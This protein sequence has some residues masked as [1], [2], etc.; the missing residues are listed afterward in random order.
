M[1]GTAR[2][3]LEECFHVS[4]SVGCRETCTWRRMQLTVMVQCVQVN[5]N[6]RANCRSADGLFHVG[7]RETCT[8]RRMQLTV[9]VPC[10][11]VNANTCANCWSADGPFHVSRRETCTWRKMQLT[12]TIPCAQVIVNTR[13]N[14]RS[15]DGPF[16]VGLFTYSV[17]GTLI[18]FKNMLQTNVVCFKV[19]CNV[20]WA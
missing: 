3:S 1:R 9:A 11:Q 16:P 13:A 14:C 8:C 12:V 10:A 17:T 18:F 20:F 7:R 15:A 2:Q 5:A 19:K 6:T 4:A